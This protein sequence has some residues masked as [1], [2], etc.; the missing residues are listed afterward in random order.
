MSIRKAGPSRFRI[1]FFA[2]PCL[3]LLVLAACGAKTDAQPPPVSAD[4]VGAEDA[5]PRVR[6]YQQPVRKYQVASYDVAHENVG[7]LDLA[8]RQI[9]V[10]YRRGGAAPKEGFDCSGLIFWVYRQSGVSMPRMAKAQSSHGAPVR[11]TLLRPGD[12]VVFRIKGAYH[13]G[14][15]SGDGLFIHSPSRGRKVREESM[16]TAYWQRHYV[17]ARR[18]I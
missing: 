18:V 3:C 2:L 14:I 16:N 10:S 4:P 6:R 12:I 17:G 15:Y 1:R 8:R 13:T 9:G 7:V 11:K 5:A